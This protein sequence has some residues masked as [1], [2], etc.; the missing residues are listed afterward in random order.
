LQETA[1]FPNAKAAL[2]QILSAHPELK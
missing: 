1:D 2:D